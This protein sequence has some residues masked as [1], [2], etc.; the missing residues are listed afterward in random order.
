MK[1]NITRKRTGVPK[2]ILSVIVVIAIAVGVF[3]YLQPISH[4]ANL[5]NF[6]PSNIMSDS[7]MSNK[8][9]MT[10]AQIQTF[11]ESKNACN[12]TNI[13]KASVYHK[14]KDGR[15]VC[16]YEDTFDGETAAHII[17]QAAQD[18]SINPQVIIVL[19]QKEQGLIT[20]TWPNSIQYN[21]A[22]GYGCPDTAACDTQYYGLKNQIRKAA[23]LYRTVLDGGWSN[24]PI[25]NNYVQYHPNAACGGTVVN[26][27]NRATS[28]LYRY[29]PYQP[30]QSALNAGYGT[31]DSCGAYGNRNFWLYFTDW[32][33]DTHST[34]D[35]VALSTPRWMQVKNSGTTKSYVFTGESAGNP[36]TAGQQIYFVDKI[37]T[38]KWYLRTQFNYDDGGYYGIDQSKLQEI[39]Y[40]PITTKWVTFTTD[41]NRSVP[42]TQK[43]VNDTLVKGTS[44]QVVDQINV[45]GNIYYRTAF[46]HDNSQDVGIA[47]RFVT[48]FTPISLDEPRNFCSNTPINKINPLTGQFVASV[49]AGTFMINKKTIINGVWY[50]QA[51]SDNGTNNFFNSNDLYSTCYVPFEG[52]RSMIL[53]QNVARINPYTNTTYDTLSKGT[54]ISLSSKIYINNQW[55]YRTK[56]NTENNMDAVIPASAFSELGT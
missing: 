4:A 55:Y 1:I 9:S 48:D 23:A 5:S 46:N 14:V 10:E 29:T 53:N 16:M 50:F 36:L 22:T 37:N 26:I 32:F 24:Y 33:G 7:V 51:D 28:A 49:S 39:P 45:N 8:D 11:L 25:G 31:G 40:Q 38:D 27:K 18:Y 34:D 17:W 52:P 15:F 12:N 21:K 6:D 56:L 44:V 54:I 47:S 13:S 30:N 20:D 2:I 3:S 19:L 43:S 41:G 42:A 35:F